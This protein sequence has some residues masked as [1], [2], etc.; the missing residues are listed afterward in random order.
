MGCSLRHPCKDPRGEDG[1]EDSVSQPMLR[2][3]GGGADKN[4]KEARKRKFAPQQGEGRPSSSEYAEPSAK[5]QRKQPSPSSG[6]EHATSGAELG[7]EAV[8]ENG[9]DSNPV[10]QQKSQRFIVFIGKSIF[11]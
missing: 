7:S 8:N 3:R 6:D 1:V 9:A 4:R 10:T 11:S 2:L 5:K